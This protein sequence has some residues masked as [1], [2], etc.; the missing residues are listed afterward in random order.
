[1]GGSGSSSG[2]D[3]GSVF[4]SSFSG[5]GSGSGS[6]SFF[7]VSF[8]GSGSDCFPFFLDS[9]SESELLELELPD[10]PLEEVGGKDGSDWEES[11]KL[12]LDGADDELE[13]LVIRSSPKLIFQSENRDIL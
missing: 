8:G 6:G 3:S 12:S 2:S 4:C 5:S 10:L 1:L 9:G 7:C 11:G 13:E